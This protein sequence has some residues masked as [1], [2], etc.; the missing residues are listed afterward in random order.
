MSIE[1]AITSKTGTDIT[2]VV[3]R[4]YALASP[5]KPVKPYIVFTRVSSNRLSLLS[6]DAGVAEAR[7]QFNIYADTY[8]QS[9][10][11][12]EE[13]RLSWQRYSGTVSGTTILDS[14]FDNDVDGYDDDIESY[15]KT[16]DFMMTYR[17]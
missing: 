5:Q 11:I 16:L 2:T 3:G 10:S 9:V 1:S 4:V 7:F 14:K 13:L 17:E 12:A 15:V 6:A 8:E